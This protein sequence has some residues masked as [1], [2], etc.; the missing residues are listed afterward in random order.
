MTI[1]SVVTTASSPSSRQPAS[2][3]PFARAISPAD[4]QAASPPVSA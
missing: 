1:T 3:A 4:A 2:R